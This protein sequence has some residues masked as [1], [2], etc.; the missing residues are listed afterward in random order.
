MLLQNL[1]RRRI[2]AVNL[3]GYEAVSI[4]KAK[5]MAE[6]AEGQLRG[7]RA[8][9]IAQEHEGRT[10]AFPPLAT[11][12]PSWRF[13]HFRP[14]A[15]LGRAGYRCLT[16]SPNQP[17]MHRAAIQEHEGRLRGKKAALRLADSFQPFPDTRARIRVG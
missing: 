4:A 16:V 12:R 2:H 7:F 8:Q 13:E 5:L 6:N 17:F 10:A 9:E 3:V 15:D 1:A 11:E 14:E